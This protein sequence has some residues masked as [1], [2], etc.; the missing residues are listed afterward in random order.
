MRR[1]C[2]LPFFV[3]PLAVLVHTERTQASDANTPM[4]G[5]LVISERVTPGF[6][7]GW[8]ARGVSEVIVPL[9]ESSRQGWGSLAKTVAQAEMHLWPWIEVARNPAMADRHPDWIAALGGHHDD[10]RRRFPNAPA[11]KKGEV[12]KAWPWVPIG[13]LPAFEAHRERLRSLLSDLPGAWTGVFLNDLQAGPSSCGCG[14]DQC[15]WV[16]DYGSPAT[17]A[18]TPGDDAAARIVSELAARHAGKQVVPVWVTE[19]E[20]ADLPNTKNGTGFCGNVPCATGSCWP[21]YA[22]NWNPLVRST[23]G[24]IALGLWT[25]TFQRD[26]LDWIGT[27]IGL[28]Q[29]PPRGGTPLPAKRVI[30]V[31]QAWQ[32]SDPKRDQLIDAL[33][34]TD[35]GWVLA[36]D[37]VDQSWEPRAVSVP[38]P[39]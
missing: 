2:L 17:T 13:Y 8:K 5:V 6:L 1:L 24:P 16:L 10:W 25:E 29:A 19:C 14:N 39:P 22:R 20:M 3:V 26:P 32:K 35:A 21:G 38:L 28:F 30:A 7:A 4:R 34:R 12:I 33:K 23:G 15:R 18:K 31:V 11:A 37:K 36:L 9:E 27:G